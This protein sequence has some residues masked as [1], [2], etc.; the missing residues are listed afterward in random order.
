[1]YGW[2]WRHLP[3]P[4]LLRVVLALLLLLV[5]VWVCFEWVFPVLAPYMPFNDN[6]VG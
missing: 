1:M 2:I 3:G 6:T 5:V 4:A